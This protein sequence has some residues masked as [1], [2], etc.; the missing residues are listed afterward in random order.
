VKILAV[1]AVAAGCGGKTAKP[2]C[3]TS[4]DELVQYLRGIDHDSQP[5]FVDS[6][7]HLAVRTDLPR[8][9]LATAPVVTVK[10]TQIV[11]ASQVVADTNELAARLSAAANKAQLYLQLDNDAKWGMIASV[12][13]AAAKSG[14]ERVSIVFARPRTGSPPPHSKVDDEIGEIVKDEQHGGKASEIAQV[15]RD[16]VASCSSMTKLFGDV[17]ATEGDKAEYL[18]DRI[19]PALVDCDCNVDVPSLRSVMYRL[20]GNPTPV[21]VLPLVLARDGATVEQPASRPWS[22]AS[23]Q[24]VSGQRVWLVAR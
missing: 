3:K 4:A 1:I 17:A 15:T 14:F 19:G 11:V 23:G 9:K 20:V 16:V 12:A 7:V 13:E 6:D 5:F 21:A 10:P 8:S 22:A 24:L 18:L 2:E